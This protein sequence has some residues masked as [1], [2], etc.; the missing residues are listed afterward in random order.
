M[1]LKDVS[2]IWSRLFDQKSVVNGEVGFFAREFEEKRG[3]TEINHLFKTIEGLTELKDS[4]LNKLKESEE[5]LTDTQLK[6]KKGLDL[7]NKF[8]DLETNYKQDLSIS[9]RKDRH[10]YIWDEIMNEISSNYSQINKLYE[11]QE[12][13]AKEAYQLLESKLGVNNM[14]LN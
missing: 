12:L 11:K 7:C 9:Q 4:H 2:K 8:P 10:K 1:W 6:I 13:E 3:D 5:I 14:Y